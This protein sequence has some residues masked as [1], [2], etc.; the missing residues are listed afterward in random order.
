MERSYQPGIMGKSSKL[1]VGR[2]KCKALYLDRKI[3]GMSIGWVDM[4]NIWV[5]LVITSVMQ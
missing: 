5:G 2:D 1:N 4:K 3:K